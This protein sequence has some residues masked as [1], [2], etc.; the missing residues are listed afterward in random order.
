M[1]EPTTHH[2]VPPREELRLR[3]PEHEEEP[4]EPEPECLERSGPR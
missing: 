1:T 4:A 3:D 2:A